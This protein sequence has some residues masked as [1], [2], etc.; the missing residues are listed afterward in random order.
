MDSAGGHW[1]KPV[2]VKGVV[3]NSM[4]DFVDWLEVNDPFMFDVV[5]AA[6]Q[7]QQSPLGF[8]ESVDWGKIG[9]TL[10][11]AGT[12]YAAYKGSKDAAELTKAKAEFEMQQS[13]RPSPRPLQRPS[14]QQA[15]AKR[16][17][18]RKAARKPKKTPPMNKKALREI[19]AR[20]KLAKQGKKQP[21]AKNY[22]PTVN[23]KNLPNYGKAVKATSGGTV[24]DKLKPFLAPAAIGVG[25]LT[26]LI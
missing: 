20:F 9:T 8:F 2:N 23:P 24:M 10:V 21:R 12:A 14:P 11:T 3:M 22:K 7:R 5:V 25:V 16:Q 19:N 13:P 6:A 26:L 1:R 15:K 17:A 18:E 4:H